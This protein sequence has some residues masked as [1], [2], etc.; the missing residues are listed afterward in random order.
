M[1]DIDNQV[2]YYAS[3]QYLSSRA[4]CQ[5]VSSCST[6]DEPQGV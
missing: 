2:D 4:S 6:R 1:L 3:N 5:D